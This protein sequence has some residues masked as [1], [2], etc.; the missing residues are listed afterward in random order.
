MLW[1]RVLLVRLIVT[2]HSKKI[3]AF[4]CTQNFIRVC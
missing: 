2:Q 1:S 4:Y 3:P